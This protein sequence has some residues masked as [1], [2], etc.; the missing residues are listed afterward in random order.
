M[1][2]YTL[3]IVGTIKYFTMQRFHTQTIMNLCIGII[4]GFLIACLGIPNNL[5]R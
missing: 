5:K 4:I 3:V 1:N 2:K